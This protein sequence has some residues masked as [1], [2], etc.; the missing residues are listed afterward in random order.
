MK[1][2]NSPL[3]LTPSTITN[4]PIPSYH[5]SPHLI[6]DNN[7]TNTYIHDPIP[8]SSTH[9]LILPDIEEPVTP[10]HCYPTRSRQSQHINLMF[11]SL[12]LKIFNSHFI[13][14][15]TNLFTGKEENFNDLIKDDCKDEW[16]SSC[17]RELG[18]CTNGVN[19]NS[20]GQNYFHFIHYTNMPPGIIPTYGKQYCTI[21]PIKA[22][23]HRTHLVVGSNKFSY[24]GLVTSPTTEQPLAKL[25]INS[26]LSTSNAKFGTLDIKDIFLMTRF[27]F[28]NDHSHMKLAVKHILQI[29][30]DNY[31]LTP[32]IHNSY[33]YYEITGRIYGLL[34]AARLA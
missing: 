17:V 29:I 27:S 15:V 23:T 14:L 30:I 5:S 8:I 19:N 18:R 10:T 28:K 21:Y 12:S 24:D 3:L 25:M 33:V 11:Q 16:V 13:N 9:N 26:T 4:F 32:L 31:N 6:L 34:H 20:L 7:D 22:E 1:L 2:S